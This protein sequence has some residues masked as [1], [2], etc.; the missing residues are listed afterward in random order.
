M[1][2][3]LLA[4]AS[5]VHDGNPPEISPADMVRVASDAGYNSVGLWIAPGDNWHRNTAGEVAAALHETGLVAI[6]V[7]V[8]WL[9]P[10]GK[11][12]VATLFRSAEA[13]LKLWEKVEK[14]GRSRD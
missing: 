14:F 6:D 4:L 11:P 5:G 12:A 3:R 10:G 9:Q 13:Y 8:I 1:S 7:E 2:E